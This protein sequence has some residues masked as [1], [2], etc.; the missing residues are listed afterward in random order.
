MENIEKIRHFVRNNLAVFDDDI[1]LQDKDN[2]FE[3]GFV[4]S[5]FAIQLVAFIEKEF[6]IQ[7][8]EEDLDITNFESIV[9]IHEFINGKQ[10]H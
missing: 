8:S 1:S 3:L 10:K 2:F 9:R 5:P 7:V 4:D 6:G